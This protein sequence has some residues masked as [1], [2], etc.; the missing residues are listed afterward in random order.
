MDKIF[1]FFRKLGE[2]ANFPHLTPTTGY[3]F[4][5]SALVA[6]ADA[7]GPGGLDEFAFGFD[8]AELVHGFFDGH[9]SDVIGLI[10]HHASDLTLLG[11][12][13]GHHA[14]AHAEDAVE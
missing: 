4:E 11:E 6:E 1:R 3:R 12:L 8:E 13:Y 7:D 14:E 9:G 10:A 5:Q 2:A